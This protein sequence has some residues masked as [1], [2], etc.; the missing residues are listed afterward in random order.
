MRSMHRGMPKVYIPVKIILINHIGTCSP[1]S[2]DHTTPAQQ[3]AIIPL[4]MSET[5]SD[6]MILATESFSK[7]RLRNV[8]KMTGTLTENAA[9]DTSAVHGANF[10][11]KN[12]RMH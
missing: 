1:G 2:R 3:A 9:R 7:R 4:T 10:L 6:A 12:D 8:T 5:A 11:L